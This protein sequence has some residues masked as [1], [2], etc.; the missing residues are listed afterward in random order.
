M[1]RADGSALGA[2]PWPKA[3]DF[4]ILARPKP[5]ALNTSGRI[6]RGGGS[7]MA[8]GSRGKGH[9]PALCIAD[10]RLYHSLFGG[11]DSA[12]GEVRG[13]RL[14]FELRLIGRRHGAED[15]IIVAARE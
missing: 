3:G 4:A 9:R 5:A 12:D 14:A 15:L 13:R 6:R 11:A 10:E 1:P 7:K 8:I 2:G